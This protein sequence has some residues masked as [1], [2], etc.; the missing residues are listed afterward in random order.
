MNYSYL[1]TILYG[2]APLERIVSQGDRY[3]QKSVARVVSTK[4]D[5][6]TLFIC[7]LTG[8][9]KQVYFLS[10]YAMK[11]SNCGPDRRIDERETAMRLTFWK[12]LK[13]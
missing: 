4:I 11:S 8:F 7:V 9:G 6:L 1:E 13:R 5:K 3:R 12:T 10:D 2:I